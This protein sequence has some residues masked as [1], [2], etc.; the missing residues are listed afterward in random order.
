[1]GG[2][3]SCT[4]DSWV[5]VH[6]GLFHVALD[7]LNHCG[8]KREREENRVNHTVRRSRDGWGRR[9][10]VEV[11]EAGWKQRYK[12]RRWGKGWQRWRRSRRNMR[13]SERTRLQAHI[14]DGT[15]RPD[16]T[17]SVLVFLSGHVLGQAARGR[18]RVSH[19]PNRKR[20][21]KTLSTK[22]HTCLSL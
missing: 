19:H 5:P 3:E 17:G 7:G 21:S 9:G 6:N 18:E 12:R 8:L 4:G 15:E 13:E 2:D 11:V 22:I 20:C 1:M 14:R 10:D 16:G